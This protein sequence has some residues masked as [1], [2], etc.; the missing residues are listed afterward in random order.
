VNRLAWDSIVPHLLKAGVDV[1]HSTARLQQYTALLLEWNR[2][3][4]NL[5][6]RSDEPRILARHIAE[7]IEPAHWLKASGCEKWLDF[8]SGGG[9]PAL[10]LAM[11]GVGSTWTLVESRRTKTLFIRRVLQEIGLERIEVVLQRL[12]DVVLEPE[13]H[14]AFEGFT[15]RAT[16]QLA[17]TLALAAPL[18]APGGK[19][20]LW[21]GSRLEAEMKADVEWKSWWDFDG[22]LGIGDGQTVVARFTRTKG[23]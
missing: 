11:C 12:E 4:S 16:M 6:A 21:K 14:A 23:E 15:S 7:S 10:P 13:R 5:I 8:G 1:E 18:I 9:L 3:V 2:T 22:L 17:P 19:A 20:F